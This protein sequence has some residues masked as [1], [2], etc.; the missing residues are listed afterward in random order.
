MQAQ[1]T[2]TIDRDGTCTLNTIQAFYA[3]RDIG[4]REWASR[5]VLLSC[6][7]KNLCSAHRFIAPLWNGNEWALSA[8]KNCPASLTEFSKITDFPQSYLQAKLTPAEF[9][10]VSP[11]SILEVLPRSEMLEQSLEAMKP[12]FVL[13]RI[14]N[15][16][17]EF[18]Y[19]DTSMFLFQ[20][21]DLKVVRATGA[22]LRPKPKPD[23]PLKFGHN[24]S[25]HM[26]EVTTALFTQIPSFSFQIIDERLWQ[27][28]WFYVNCCCSVSWP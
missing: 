9:D 16:K 6:S 19:Q 3:N 11:S 7:W 21:R 5:K 14:N 24:F 27:P 25:D 8:D 18:F 17:Y 2:S 28:T 22:Q 12:K 1:L 10:T 13:R 23:D 4:K 15:Q 20:Y 26:F